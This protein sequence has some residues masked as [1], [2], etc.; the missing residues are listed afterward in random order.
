MTMHTLRSITILLVLAGWTVSTN[1][2]LA[3]PKLTPGSKRY[4][5]CTCATQ[6]S[7]LFNPAWDKKCDCSLAN[8]KKC[9]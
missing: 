2:A 9:T 8:N 4:C 3:V 7:V 6:D 5:S 1:P